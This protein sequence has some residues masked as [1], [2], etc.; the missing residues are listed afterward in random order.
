MLEQQQTKGSSYP[1][2]QTAQLLDL[3]IA[4]CFNFTVEDFGV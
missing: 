2:L 3:G 1:N 4:S